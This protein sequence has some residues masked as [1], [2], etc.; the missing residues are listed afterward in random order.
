[1]IP[2]E[3]PSITL[4]DMIACHAKWRGGHPAFV[5]GER[6]VN[7]RDFNSLVNRVANILLEWGLRRGDS[8]GVFMPDSIESAATYFGV[9]KAGAVLVP[10]SPMIA[11]SAIER[12]IEDAQVRALF[13]GAP[14]EGILRSFATPVEEILPDRLVALGFVKEGW[15][16][17]NHLVDRS[18]AEEPNVLLDL[19]D[20]FVIVY[21]SGTT[22]VPKGIVHTHRSRVR[23][24][25]A[26]SAAL[27]MGKDTRGL[28]TTPIFTNGTWI[29]L[30]PTVMYGGTIVFLEG[31]TPKRFLETVERHSATHSLMVPTQYIVTLQDPEFEN[32]D[33]SSLQTL[34]SV[35]STLRQDVRERVL[36]AF[37]CEFFEVY[38]LTEGPGTM[39]DRREMLEKP[40]SVGKPGLGTDIR[41]IDMDG[42]ELP[43]GEVGEIVGYSSIMMKTYHNR[44]DLTEEILWKD[45][46]GRN[47]FKTGDIGKLDEDGFLYI[48]DRKRDMI[49][50]GGVNVFACDIEQ[51]FGQHPDVLDVAVIG[52]PHEKWGESPLALVVRKSNAVCTEAEL[53][54]W[55]NER[56]GK[57]QR[58]LAVEFREEFSRN[59]LGKILKKELRS[60]YWEQ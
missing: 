59:A 47:Y 34:V 1:M 41:I 33:L 56:L 11:P 3:S 31:F 2:L 10:L 30:C 21:S 50:T 5:Q 55:A 45:E 51:V 12:M 7:W 57:Y 58:V 52:V 49:V 20:T 8:V 14:F 38:G 46:R 19:E 13:V 16:E 54:E 48:L 9:V 35:G 40:G 60:P 26:L 29:I 32:F 25:H 17:F 36:K 53:K 24:G 22:G 6:T 15:G 44:P 23:L 42:K 43:R 4:P 18:S 37:D 27:G 39:I 28:L